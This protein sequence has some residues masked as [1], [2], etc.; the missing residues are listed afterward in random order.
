LDG[1]EKGGGKTMDEQDNHTPPKRQ[2]PPLYEKVVPIALGVIVIVIVV[3][4]LIIFAVALGLFP[5][6]G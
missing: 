3:L 5:G 1:S 4:V 6:S 2:Y